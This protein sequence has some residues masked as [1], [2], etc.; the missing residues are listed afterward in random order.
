[1]AGAS[2][3]RQTRTAH[4]KTVADAKSVSDEAEAQAV[5]PGEAK[6]E[7]AGETEEGGEEAA[8]LQEGAA[9]ETVEEE[10]PVMG[11]WVGAE[12]PVAAA[13]ARQVERRMPQPGVRPGQWQTQRARQ[14]ER[15]V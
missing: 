3:P 4:Q 10:A 1:V 13:G 15:T 12:I 8:V 9:T 5:V 2:F 14:P 6:E 7:E 11:G